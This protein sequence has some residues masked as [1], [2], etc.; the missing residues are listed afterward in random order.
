MLGLTAHARDTPC[1]GAPAPALA[2]PAP[3]ALACVPAVSPASGPLVLLLAALWLTASSSSDITQSG[4]A[5]VTYRS[6][7]QEPRRL[8]I[9]PVFEG[10]PD[11]QYVWHWQG[12]HIF[13]AGNYSR[14]DIFK[15]NN[16]NPQ[17][18]L[19]NSYFL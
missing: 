18:C 12:F 17:H 13:R 14:L 16:D 9:C 11:N 8:R 6:Y 15:K 5:A 19:R 2:A 1:P 3:G 4:T 7:N 10:L